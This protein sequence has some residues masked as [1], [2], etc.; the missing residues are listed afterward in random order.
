[1]HPQSTHPKGV[2]ERQGGGWISRDI[3]LAFICLRFD[4]SHPLPSHY[5]GQLPRCREITE[6]GVGEERIR[7]EKAWGVMNGICRQTLHSASIHGRGPQ[8]ELSSPLQRFVLVLLPVKMCRTMPASPLCLGVSTKP[9][10]GALGW[11]LWH[12]PDFGKHKGLSPLPRAVGAHLQSCPQL[13]WCCS[14][15]SA[16]S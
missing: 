9:F 4:M 16:C 1:M 5:Q 6:P 10:K 11:D 7:Q 8:A 14:S 3:S 15:I 13:T 12:Y 2:F